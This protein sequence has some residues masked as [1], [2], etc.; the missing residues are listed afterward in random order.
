MR[1]FIRTT[2]VAASLALGGIVMSQQVWAAD[3]VVEKKVTTTSPSGVVVI[4]DEA[5]RSFKLQGQTHTYI[6][7]SDADLKSLSGKDVTLTVNPDGS[8]T[9]VERKTTTVQ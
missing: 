9:K 8:V 1:H 2:L 5:A 3:V 4:E 6:A 7:P